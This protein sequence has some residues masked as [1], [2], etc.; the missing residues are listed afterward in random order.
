MFVGEGGRS[1]GGRGERGREGGREGE[2]RGGE[3]EREGRGREGGGRR[4][5]EAIFATTLVHNWV[6]EVWV[7]WGHEGCI[8]KEGAILD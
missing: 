4:E 7:F 5:G 3:R 1:E 2:R 6:K 8:Q